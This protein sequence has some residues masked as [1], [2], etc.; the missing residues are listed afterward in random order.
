MIESHGITYPVNRKKDS[1]DSGLETALPECCPKLVSVFLVGV[2]PGK[3][4][5]RLR[6]IFAADARS[7][8]NAKL[9][10]V[11]NN[12]HQVDVLRR[13][14]FKRLVIISPLYVIRYTGVQCSFER[15]SLSGLQCKFTD[16]FIVPLFELYR[17]RGFRTPQRT[18]SR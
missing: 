11:A 10:D 16:L 17:S 14:S 12:S 15:S 6:I 1:R 5:S 8:W 9:I 3:K 7:S 4:G 13:F 2:I 18:T